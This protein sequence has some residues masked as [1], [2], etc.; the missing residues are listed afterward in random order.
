MAIR[1]DLEYRLTKIEAKKF[2]QAITSARKRSPSDDV[3]PRVHQAT[4]EALESELA[5]LREQ[6]AGYEALKS[7]S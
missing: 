7:R 3:D 1:T 6:L 4:I 2:E 5:V